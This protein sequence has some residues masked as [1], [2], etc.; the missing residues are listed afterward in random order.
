MNF[1]PPDLTTHHAPITL[2]LQHVVRPLT[3]SILTGLFACGV[4]AVRI[5]PGMVGSGWP[6]GPGLTPDESFN[7]LQGY[8][9]ADAFLEHG[10]LLWTPA[11]AD[12][13]FGDPDYLPDHPPLGRW[14]LGFSH[15]LT[16]GWFPGAQHMLANVPAARLGSCFALGLT[17]FLVSEFCR[18]RFGSATA[19]LAAGCLLLMPRVVGHARLATLET[20][21]SLAWLAA[22]LPLWSWWTA[23]RP[24]TLRQSFLSGLLFGLLLLTKVQGILV[25]PLVVAWALYQFRHRAVV[26]LLVWGLTAGAVFFVGW[27]WLWLDP[28]G[29]TLAYLG[30]A[31]DRQTLYVWYFGTRYE[32]KLVPWHYPFV[33]TA[34]TVPVLVL[35]PVLWKVTRRPLSRPELL[36][37]ASVCWPL[38]VFAVPGTPVYDGTRLFLVVM[39][40]LA[41]LAGR[42]VAEFAAGLQRFRAGVFSAAVLLMLPA[43]AQV[44]SPFAISSYSLLVG[45]QA[46]AQAI[47]MES[48]YWVEGWNGSFWNQVPRGATVYVAPVSHQFQLQALETMVPVVAERNLRLQP[49]Y[50]DPD[51]QRGLLLLNHRLADLRPSLRDLPDGTAVVADVRYG[52]V[53]LVRLIDTRTQ[54]LPNSVDPHP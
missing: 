17:I 46:G 27:P 39:P 26:P 35:L 7:I 11:T 14:L 47:G 4:A 5:D 24:P 20:A 42:A 30:R 25:P 10:P 19:L 38:L 53:V 3:L 22:F 50:Y 2:N 34:I 43:M 21:T 12:E 18:R 54:P 6:D 32:D 48:A 37:A 8:Y 33:M 23:Q 16:S 9:L 36:I 1:P 45:Q 28:V 52:G 31:A 15:E 44:A 49:Y 40:A 41:I 29:N 51:R 13:V